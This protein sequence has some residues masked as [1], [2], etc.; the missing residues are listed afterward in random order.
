MLSQD[1]FDRALEL[2]EGGRLIPAIKELRQKTGF[3]LKEAKELAEAIRDGASLS[4]VNERF[5][6][7][8]PKKE[9][10]KSDAEVVELL[11]NGQKIRAIKLY[12]ELHGVGLKEAKL[13]VEAIERDPGSGPPKRSTTATEPWLEKVRDLISVGRKIEAIKHYRDHT[14]AGLAEAKRAVD[15]MAREGVS[16]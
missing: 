1:D 9:T 10:P 2:I 3:G 14:G 5:G 11:N 4:E 12:R 16:G 8:T 15:D 7:N 6:L 13:A